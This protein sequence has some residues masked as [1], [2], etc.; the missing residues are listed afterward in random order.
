MLDKATVE[1]IATLARIGITPEECEQ[2]QGELSRVLDFVDELKAFESTVTEGART[3]G[4]STTQ[5][6]ADHERNAAP[7][8]REQI[9]ANMPHTKDGALTVRKVL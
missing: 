5:S 8:V 3:G 6:R 1:H 2:Y 4:T 9:I 7:E